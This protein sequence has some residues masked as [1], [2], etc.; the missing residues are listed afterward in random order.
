M[1][2]YFEYNGKRSSDFGIRI[3]NKMEFVSPANDIEFVKVQGKDGDYAIDNHR[4]ESINKFLYFD[5]IIDDSVKSGGDGSLIFSKSLEIMEWLNTKKYM[6]LKFSMYPSYEYMAMFYEPNTI[7]D[8]MRTL[9]NGVLRYRIKPIM[10]LSDRETAVVN[11]GS[12]VVN[13]GS[14]PSMPR[15]EIVTNTSY[16]NTDVTISKNGQSWIRLRN[17]MNGRLVIDSEAGQVTFNNVL[18][19][20]K[21]L[22]TGETF[23][24]L[25]VGENVITFDTTQIKE[26]NIDRREGAVAI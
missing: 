15:I 1:T 13:E 16:S 14:I 21:M 26:M 9:G 19:N 2:S 17:V 20:G 22:R 24:A 3:Y 5:L 7:A 4:L 6:P 11:N 25:D 8:T 12:T 18:N 10:Y 23:P